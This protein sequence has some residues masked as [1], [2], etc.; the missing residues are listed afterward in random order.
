MR[1]L[2]AQENALAA[3]GRAASSRAP[4]AEVAGDIVASL[5]EVV[6]T[7]ALAISLADPF[8]GE[9]QALVNE[10]YGAPVLDYIDREFTVRDPGFREIVA[11]RWPKRMQ[12]TSFDYKAGYSYLEVWRPAG[13]EEGLTA[14]LIT[15]D[16]RYVGMLN[17]SV[18][19]EEQVPDAV[20]E[21]FGVLSPIL[22]GVFDPLADLAGWLQDDDV[23]RRLVV[24]ADGKVLD[25]PEVEEDPSPR[26]RRS[27][28]VGIATRMLQAD[29]PVRRGLIPDDHGRL[30]SVHL[31]RAHSRRLSERPFVLASL[32]EAEVPF[33]L[34]VRETEVLRQLIAGR[35]NREIADLLGV[36]PRTVATHIEHLLGK[37]GAE[38]RT[39]VAARA[40][41]QGLVR[42]DLDVEDTAAGACPGLV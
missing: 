18:E 26:V 35:S 3:V 2:S 17:L 13:Y 37:F 23:T 19:R 38:T 16:D 8:T 40:L 24:D 21:F 10:G 11:E 12:D 15:E 41:E 9:H 4:R 14:A 33:G 6:D 27:T 29:Q 39:A 31:A 34:T 32:R 28:L 5:R 25:C 1:R 36:A 30:V 22:A 42:L 7:S 20:R